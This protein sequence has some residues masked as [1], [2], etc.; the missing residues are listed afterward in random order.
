MDSGSH[1]FFVDSVYNV[2]GAAERADEGC[3][4]APTK[5][6]SAGPAAG[7][8]GETFGAVDKVAGDTD[9]FRAVSSR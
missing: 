5:F 3:G 9:P 6:P 8:A 1:G 2:V 7:A 4:N